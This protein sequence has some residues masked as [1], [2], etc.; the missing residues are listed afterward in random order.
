MPV[1]GVYGG[2]K[3]KKREPPSTAKAY[4]RVNGNGRQK[5]PLVIS[6]KL[7]EEETGRKKAKKRGLA[8]WLCPYC[9]VNN[10]L[11]LQGTDCGS[12]KPRGSGLNRFSYRWGLKELRALG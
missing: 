2:E 4:R 7:V 6:L 11:F 9:S 10:P 8:M 12:A 1:G 3:G 5:N